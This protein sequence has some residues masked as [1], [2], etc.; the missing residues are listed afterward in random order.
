MLPI[1]VHVTAHH[2]GAADPPL[3]S[4]PPLQARELFAAEAGFS[5]LRRLRGR[6][7]GHDVIPVYVSFASTADATA[8]KAKWHRRIL[9]GPEGWVR[10]NITYDAEFDPAKRAAAERAAAKR[11]AATPFPREGG[12]VGRAEW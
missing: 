8:A 11:D 1:L 12:G 2:A 5:T 6:V 7:R 3:P 9:T 10:L 4:P